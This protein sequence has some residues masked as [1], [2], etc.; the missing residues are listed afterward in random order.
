MLKHVISLIYDVGRYP[1]HFDIV[2]DWP[3]IIKYRHPFYV[4]HNVCKHYAIPSHTT[5]SINQESLKIPTCNLTSLFYLELYDTMV[6]FFVK[7]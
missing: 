3:G 2:D 6:S 7:L 5:V 1:S 4:G